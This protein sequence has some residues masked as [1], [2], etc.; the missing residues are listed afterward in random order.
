M[1]IFDR[2]LNKIAIRKY[3][4][5]FFNKLIMMQKVGFVNDIKGI[6]EKKR[7]ENAKKLMQ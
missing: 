6:K 4:S 7:T 2:Y 5:M 3:E 1:V